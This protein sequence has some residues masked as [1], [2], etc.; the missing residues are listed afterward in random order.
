MK[1]KRLTALAL[2]L[3]L[4]LGLAGSAS[5]AGGKTAADFPDFDSGAW[6]AQAVSAAVDNGL[7]E[8]TDQG[9]LN[10]EGNLTRAE[11][12]VILHRVLTL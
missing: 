8:G 12:A 11:M 2:S 1:C 9:K 3:A 4:S 5:A 6:Y 7:L 10:P